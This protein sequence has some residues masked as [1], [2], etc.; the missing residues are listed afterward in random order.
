MYVIALESAI[1]HQKS[2]S[3]I[4]QSVESV[5]RGEGREG[6][7]RYNRQAEQ[8]STWSLKMVAHI[9]Q[10]KREKIALFT[11]EFSMKDNDRERKSSLWIKLTQCNLGTLLFSLRVYK[12]KKS[13]LPTWK[14]GPMSTSK[15]RSANPVAITLAPLSC[16]SWPIFA[17]KIRGRRPSCSTKAWVRKG[18]MVTCAQK[19]S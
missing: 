2:L 11:I 7:N 13:W 16:P 18:T 9:D 1:F 17:T 4:R 3:W 8:D 6:G 15:P 5:L 12:E 19:G 10:N 14:R